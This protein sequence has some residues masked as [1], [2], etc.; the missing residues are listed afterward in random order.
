M[1]TPANQRCPFY[2]SALSCPTTATIHQDDDFASGLSSS[3]VAVLGQYDD[4]CV[5]AVKLTIR[6]KR[7]LPLDTKPSV[8]HLWSFSCS[9]AVTGHWMLLLGSGS[10]SATNGWYRDVVDWSH[11]RPTIKTRL[12]WQISR[13]SHQPRRHEEGDEDGFCYRLDLVHGASGQCGYWCLMVIPE[14]VVFD[15]RRSGIVYCFTK[16]MFFL[17]HCLS[18]L[19][20][21]ALGDVG[22]W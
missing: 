9:F 5:A 11:E 16:R 12:P 19:N 13:Y 4:R 8:I 2:C 10:V 21:R 7:K 3:A 18:Y 20:P 1:S 22:N 15:C 17:P 6:S 14:A